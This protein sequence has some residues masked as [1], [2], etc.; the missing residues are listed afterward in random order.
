MIVPEFWSEAKE[1]FSI[2]G[3][4]R[5]LKRFGW[6]DIDED[7]AH[8]NAQAR[9]RDAAA[10]AKNGE[11]VRSI[12][13]K[14]P[15]N[16]ADGVPIREEIVERFDETVITR[17]S[18]GALCLNTP[19][20]LFTDIDIPEQSHGLFIS[21]WFFLFLAVGFWL[22]ST[23]DAW[24]PLLAAFVA[25]IV[26]SSMLAKATASLVA[27]FQQNPFSEA[28]AR[29]ESFAAKNSSWKLRVYRTPLGYRVMAMHA[30]FDPTTEE[31]FKFME[32]LKSDPLY[33]LMC[34]NQKC[35]RARISPKPWRIGMEHIRPRPGVWPIKQEHLSRRQTWVSKYA[36]KSAGFASCEYVGTFGEGRVFADCER[37]RAIHDRFCKSDSGLPI[38]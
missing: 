24:W 6:S 8:R 25:A 3:R 27:K 10:R 23:M 14:T 5:T 2:D 35:F 29:I 28:L 11:T 22:M 33:V 21:I 12:D 20:I 1:Q 16:G 26:T 36:K 7:D 15:Y 13:R 9:V 4:T 37:V 38:A 31:P 30:T 32:T 18:Y 19:N 34:R 17:N